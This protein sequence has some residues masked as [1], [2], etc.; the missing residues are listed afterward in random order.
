MQ[1]FQPVMYPSGLLPLLRSS[2]NPDLAS[3]PISTEIESLTQKMQR[4]RQFWAH[5]IQ[6]A[7]SSLVNIRQAPS[8]SQIPSNV[9]EG[10]SQTPVSLQHNL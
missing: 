7:A 2:S 10:P 5:G 6:V 4:T 1:P 9:T 3:D 8:Q